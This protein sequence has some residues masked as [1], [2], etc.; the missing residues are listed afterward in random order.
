MNSVDLGARCNLIFVNLKWKFSTYYKDLN[1]LDWLNVWRI[2][3]SNPLP[4][5]SGIELCTEIINLLIAWLVFLGLGFGS[6]S[7]G[8]PSGMQ[9][10]LS[11]KIFDQLYKCSFEM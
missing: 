9:S 8:T 6:Q 1:R 11:S 10:I 3:A 5:T 7:V 4:H 2:V